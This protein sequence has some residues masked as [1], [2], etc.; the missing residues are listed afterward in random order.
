[1]THIYSVHSEQHVTQYGVKYLTKPGAVLIAQPQL[2][3][4]GIEEFGNVISELDKEFADYAQDQITDPIAH[5]VKLAGQGC[6]QSWGPKRTFNEDTDKYIERLLRNSD[7]SV[8]EHINF[9]VWLYG[10]GRDT[11][12]EIVRH[13]AGFGYSQLSQRYVD[14]DHIR[15]VLRPEYAEDEQLRTSFFEW[16]K[17]ALNEYAW[18]AQRLLVLQASTEEYKALSAES[19]TEARKKVNQAA[20]ACLPNETETQMFITANA[21]AWRH[22]VTTRG[23]RRADYYTRQVAHTVFTLLQSA[24]PMVWQDFIVNEQSDGVPSIEPTYVKV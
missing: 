7:G 15:F 8:L 13:R 5:I 4:S 17:A 18:R 14:D 12:H 3:Y 21:R 19:K 16:T 22:F 2:L 24:C 1:M 23:A 11:S 9:T 20:R 6:Y 10:I